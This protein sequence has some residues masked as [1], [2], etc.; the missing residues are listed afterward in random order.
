MNKMTFEQWSFIHVGPTILPTN[1]QGWFA[2]QYGDF[3]MK[4][5]NFGNRQMKNKM[6]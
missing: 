2:K 1:G 6:L 4:L 3:K 5:D